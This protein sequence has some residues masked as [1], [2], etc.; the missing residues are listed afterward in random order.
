MRQG[1]RSTYFSRGAYFSDSIWVDSEESTYTRTDLVETFQ[2]FNEDLAARLDTS[3]LLQSKVTFRQS[4]ELPT[5]ETE[6]PDNALPDTRTFCV[7]CNFKS[8]QIAEPLN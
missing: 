3:Q 8:V 4:T 1:N 6:V 5:C 2:S 7:F